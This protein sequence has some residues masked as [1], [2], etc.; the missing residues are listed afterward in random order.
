MLS[1]FS[2]VCFIY[3][4]SLFSYVAVSLMWQGTISFGV[5]FFFVLIGWP[6]I[7]MILEA[8]GFIV[9]FR[10]GLQYSFAFTDPFVCEGSQLLIKIVM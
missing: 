8:Y 1:D 2:L 9:L 7:G 10:S 4:L 3:H 5:G 6:V